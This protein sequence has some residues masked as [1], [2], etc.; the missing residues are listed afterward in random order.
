ML[1]KNI[2]DQAFLRLFG[3]SGL[4][5]LLM[6]LLAGCASSSNQQVSPGPFPSQPMAM[7]APDPS[8][9]PI[10]YVPEDYT[11][12]Q[13]AVDAAH[14]GQIVSIAPGIYHEAVRVKT[15]GITIR[16]LDRNQVILEGDYKLPN[17]I[18]IESNQVVVENMTARHY[19]G[20]GFY[21]DGGEDT[22]NPLIGYRGSYLT[23]ISNGD[24]GIYAFNAQD[25]MF[26][27]DYASG[28]PDSGFYIGQCYPC[29]AI[30]SNVTSE[31]NALGY[32]G[33][34][35]GG[36][37]IIRDS[38]WDN[39]MSGILPNTLDSEKNPPEHQTTI[40]NNLVYSNNNAK[41]PAKPLEYAL[42]GTGIGLPGGNGNVVIDNTVRDQQNYG[43]IIIG[44][45]DDNFWVASDNRI[46]G[47][48]VSNSGVADLVLSSPTGTGNCF[49]DNTADS[50]LPPLIQQK[51]PCDSGLA[52]L[53]GG[54]LGITPVVLSR[55]IY[56]RS[57]SFH[58]TK[59]N[60]PLVPTPPAQPDMLNSD[61]PALPIF[62]DLSLFNV[63]AAGATPNIDSSDLTPLASGGIAVFHLLLALYGDVLPIALYAAWLSVGFWDLGRN[64]KL[65]SGVKLV[66]MAV[67]VVIPILGPIAYFFFGRSALSRSFRIM[68]VV[69]APVLFL[70]MAGLLTWVASMSG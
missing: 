11:T 33:T 19:A 25:G 61:G 2:P 31:W 3:L 70:A 24:Y 59:Y 41:A 39:N 67:M 8:L 22:S 53:Q 37:L 32:S 49:S 66:W 48:T 69:G 55:F 46:I 20:N 18:E 62:T 45:L 16:G 54:D 12:I 29:N 51:Y 65:S 52:Q 6:G 27:H 63:P 38:V 26:D 9:S 28:S 68:F 30:I 40:Y 13:G 50:S 42:I 5:L 36:N 17:A 43:I 60:D 64:E 58:P 21:W 15:S 56:A 7:P 35:A 34:N 44:N 57:G 14:P 47:N 4:L 23:A 1:R 10:L